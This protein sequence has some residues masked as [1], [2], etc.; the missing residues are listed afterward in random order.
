MRDANLPL[1]TAD[2]HNVTS[3]LLHHGRQ[4]GWGETEA[5]HIPLPC[6]FC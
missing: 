1:Q 5:E 4:Q 2:Y 6:L 3:S